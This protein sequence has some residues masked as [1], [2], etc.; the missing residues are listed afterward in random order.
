[1]LRQSGMGLN[2]YDP[3]AYDPSVGKR[4]NN[5]DGD[6]YGGNA[7]YATTIAKPGQKMQVNLTLNN[8]TASKITFELFNYLDSYTRT[9]KASYVP[10]NTAYAYYPL[11][12][13]EGISRVSTG[14]SGVVGFDYQGNL[15]ITGAGV[16][17]SDGGDPWA[18]IACGEI[19]YASFF[20]ASGII[21]FQVA[22]F[23]MTVTTDAQINQNIVYLKKS[24]SGG[25][26]E[27]PVS[28]RSYFRP[29]QFQDKTIDITVNFPIGIDTGLRTILLP[30]E[31]VQYALFIQVWTGQT[32][33]QNG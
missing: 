20:E 21:P 1:M 9:R 4:F 3:D 13:F 33:L 31:T 26:S 7:G 12:S 14:E 17:D 30:S 28:P 27:N 6:D 2:T 32:V 8:P 5:A 29:N 22:W 11:S 25:V 18:T 10:T 15:I 16:P 23:R 24:Y 19:A